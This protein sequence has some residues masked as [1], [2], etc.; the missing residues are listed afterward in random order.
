MIRI[1]GYFK[2]LNSPVLMLLLDISPGPFATHH[3]DCP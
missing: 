2:E 3:K 1:T